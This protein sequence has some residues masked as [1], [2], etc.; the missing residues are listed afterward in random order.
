MEN[1][2][3]ALLI[4]GGILIALLIIGAFLLMFNTLG[5][6][7]KDSTALVADEQLASFNDEYISMVSDS[8]LTGVKIISAANKIQDYNDKKT[9]IGKIEWSEITLEIDLSKATSANANSIREFL[10]SSTTITQEE[11]CKEIKDCSNTERELGISVMNKIT[12][13]YT[14]IYDSG[15]DN[16]AKT[17]LL[18]EITGLNS[19]KYDD[20]NDATAKNYYYYSLLKKAKFKF[21]GEE[22]DDTGKIKKLSVELWK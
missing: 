15:L 14:K 3:Q 9:A 6:Y 19:I 1:A 5:D 16:D 11:F 2:T 18:K 21:T 10:K 13:N 22:Y 17:A 7:Q 8:D 20:V 4:A 12:S